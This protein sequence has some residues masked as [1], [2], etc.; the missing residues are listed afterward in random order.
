MPVHDQN[1]LMELIQSSQSG[2]LSLRSLFVTYA[3]PYTN[4]Q[5]DELQQLHDFKQVSPK[6]KVQHLKYFILIQCCTMSIIQ[7]RTAVLSL[8]TNSDQNGK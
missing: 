6:T 4:G 7:Y 5:S 2:I 1:I 3:E 8:P